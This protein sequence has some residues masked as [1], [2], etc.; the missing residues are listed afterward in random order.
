M[1]HPWDAVTDERWRAWL[2]DG[3]D[4]GTLIVA[5]RERQ[6]PVVVPT[7]FVFRPDPDTVLLHLARPNPVWAALAEN[8]TVVLS[9]IGEYVYVPTSW[10]ADP[11]TPPTD[12]VP[13]SYYTAVQLIGDAEVLDDP[14]RKAELLTEQ[15]G[16][17]QP[18]GG[19]AAVS[20]SG[21]PYARS[22][23][24]I[25]G[26]RIAVTQVVAKMKYGGN[27]TPAH[28]VEI[29]QHLAERAGPMDLLARAYVLEL[30]PLV[31]EG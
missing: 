28:R 18:E 27:K 25:R 12:G 20:A 5:G 11:G 10:N 29:T 17:F 19:H 26:V 16:H 4:F 3:H 31:A 23:P 6:V 7:H 30:D 14:R 2:A 1:V 24:G 21:S 22:L 9:V 15:L 13:T 8:P